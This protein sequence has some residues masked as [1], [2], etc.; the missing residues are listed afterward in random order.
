[1]ISPDPV[2]EA[3]RLPGDAP[4]RRSAMTIPRR[5]RRRRRRRSG[6]SWPRPAG[7]SGRARRPASGPCSSA[8]ATSSTPK[9]VMAGRY[10]WVLA[11]DEP[12]I[13]GYDQAL[14]VERLRHGTDDPADLLALFEPLRQANVALWG[15]TTPIDRARI[16]V[17]RERGVGEPRSHVPDARRP[18]PHPP[19]PGAGRARGRA[20]RPGPS[21]DRPRTAP[22][23]RSRRCVRRPIRAGR[24]RC[25]HRARSGGAG[26]SR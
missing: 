10:R 2:R 20:G 23:A 15:R 5:C 21:G 26:S 19:R 11:Q 6:R 25:R 22:A 9:L 4:R 7:S 16:G 12:E 1:M 17:H 14:W 3:A 8:S 18:R 24:R 13:V